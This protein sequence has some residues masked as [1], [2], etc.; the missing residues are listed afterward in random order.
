MTPSNVAGVAKLSGLD[1]VALTD[2]NSAKNCPAFFKAADF[3]G[4]TPIAGVELTTSEDIHV[5]CLFEE[6]SAALDFDSDLKSHRMLVPNKVEVFGNQLIMD[7]DDNVIGTDEYYL[8]NAT[9]IS[10]DESLKFVSKY[11]GICYPAHI[12]R[13]SNGAIAVLGT[14]PKHPH[15]LQA[16]F[17]DVKNIPEYL[18]KYPILKE[19]EIVFGSDAHYLLWIKDRTSYFELPDSLNPNEIRAE[20]FKHLRGESA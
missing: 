17:S 11:G 1:I 20:L 8:P 14:F 7:E 15:F 6:L 19:K 12:D 5:V 4:L 10:I 9:D 18:E 2:H 16:E 3:Y 13:E